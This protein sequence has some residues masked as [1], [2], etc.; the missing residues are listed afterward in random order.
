MNQPIPPRGAPQWGSPQDP[1]SAP[2][3]GGQPPAPQSWGQP[4]PQQWGQP[5]VPQHP[6]WVQPPVQP[7]APP[8]VNMNV[9]HNVVVDTGSGGPPFLLR[10]VWFVFFGWWLSWIVVGFAYLLCLTLIGLPVGFALFNQ[11]PAVLTLRPRTRM[12]AAEVRDGVT[13]VT[14]RNVPQMSFLVR[15]LWFLLV[16]WWL[17]AIYLGLA[18]FLCVII[19]TLPI[20]LVMFNRVG[21]V[22]TLLRY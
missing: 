12:Y 4:P 7:P 11:L 8:W 21:A 9:Q 22:M 15:A 3:Q 1:G 10:A 5:P 6:Q 19:I 17:G 16:G 13:F 2:Q 14:G 20:G 18:W